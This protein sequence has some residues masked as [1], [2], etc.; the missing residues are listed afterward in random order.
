[1][2]G[3]KRRAKTAPKKKRSTGKPRST[4]PARGRQARRRTTSTSGLTARATAA[5]TAA[6]PPPPVVPLA[7]AQ[8]VASLRLGVF[9]SRDGWSTF[10]VGPYAGNP[11][12][13]HVPFAQRVAQRWLISRGQAHLGPA[14][15][16]FTETALVV[17][18]TPE[19]ITAQLRDPHFWSH[20]AV[21]DWTAH[22]DGS[23]TYALFPAG[24]LAG[25]KVNERMH[26]PE[27]LPDGAWVV[28]IDLSRKGNGLQLLPGQA[29]G[30]AYVHLK[31]RFDG[32]T[33]VCGRFAGVRE[34]N[35]LFSA[36]D[37]AKNHLLCERGQLRSGES[38]FNKL[39]PNGTGLGEMLQRAEQG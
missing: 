14:G 34:F 9:T 18:A 6:P 17:R 38:L 39:L 10:F 12:S 16:I 23:F 20:G 26:A 8:T 32:A 1:M 4:T 3:P 37:F 15:A 25:V 5:P 30:L 27:R 35:P 24:H 29:E 21:V 11:A 36:E 13:Q 2:A 28:R 33:E 7:S 22:P 19:R 31:P